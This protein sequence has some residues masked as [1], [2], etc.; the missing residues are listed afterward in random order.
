MMQLSVQPG[1]KASKRVR[2]PLFVGA[3]TLCKAARLFDVP[4]FPAPEQ[5]A[6]HWSVLLGR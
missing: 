3:D 5:P 1:S 2:A 6:S 4:A